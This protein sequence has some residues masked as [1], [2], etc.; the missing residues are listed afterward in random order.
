M[1]SLTP[2]FMADSEPI[3]GALRL[4]TPEHSTS[5]LPI[6][7]VQRDRWLEAVRTPLPGPGGCEAGASSCLLGAFP[8]LWLAYIRSSLWQ[9]PCFIEQDCWSRWK[10]GGR[11]LRGCHS[12]CLVPRPC[13]AHATSHRACTCGGAPTSLLHQ[14]KLLSSLEFWVPICCW[15]FPTYSLARVFFPMG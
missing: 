1:S 9:L 12:H 11:R 8:L 5:V 10:P 14:V 2:S 6:R 15:L 13:A 4:Q 7:G 3:L